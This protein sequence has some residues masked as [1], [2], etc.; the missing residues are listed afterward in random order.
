MVSLEGETLSKPG[1]KKTLFPK[2][3][4]ATAPQTF[5]EVRI[6]FFPFLRFGDD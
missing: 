6:L 4:T 2:P 1:Q 5:F 3:Y